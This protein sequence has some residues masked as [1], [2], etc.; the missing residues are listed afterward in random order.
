MQKRA[1]PWA[2]KED[3]PSSVH[4]FCDLLFIMK[5]WKINMK[6]RF[7]V[8]EVSERNIKFTKKEPGRCNLNFL[9]KSFLINI[10]LSSWYDWNHIHGAHHNWW[11]D[12]CLWDAY[13]YSRSY[14]LEGTK[15]AAVYNFAGVIFSLELHNTCVSMSGSILVLKTFSKF[16]VTVQM[17]LCP[18]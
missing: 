12:V 2:Y 9:G 7:S 10:V 4:P 18:L 17:S 14:S 11:W 3:I 15:I 5:S 6:Y 8:K 13:E 16:L 1:S